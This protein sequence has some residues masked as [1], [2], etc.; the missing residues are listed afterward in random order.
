[1]KTYKLPVESMDNKNFLAFKNREDALKPLPVTV[2]KTTSFQAT[3]QGN[4]IGAHIA[5]LN[6]V[7][8]D[9]K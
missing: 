6:S 7:L 9:N 1:M 2:K 8:K 3:Y 5:K 4:T